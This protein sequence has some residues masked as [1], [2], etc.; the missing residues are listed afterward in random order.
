M[1]IMEQ[2]LSVS[3]VRQNL[4]G[5]L[6]KLQKNP[7]LSIKITLNN[8]PVGELRS[9]TAAQPRMN[10]GSV[11]VAIGK[12]SENGR[13]KKKAGDTSENHDLYLYS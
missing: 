7:A 3:T 13:G 12:K 8:L 6:R 9:V 10:V 11:L 4:S 5:L 1:Y 2:S